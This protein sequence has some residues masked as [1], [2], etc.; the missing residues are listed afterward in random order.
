MKTTFLALAACALALTTA[1]AGPALTQTTKT[2]LTQVDPATLTTA[3]R[4]SQLIG[5]PV[6]DDAGTKIG[7]VADMLVAA[8][9]TV[10]YALITNMP[11]GREAERTVVVAASNFELIGDRL[12]IHGV[13][14][15][16]LLSLPNF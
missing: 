15:T 8:N 9:G 10:P 6:Y 13:T 14:A 2:M 12:T 3:W 1:V 4:A 16:D 11:P 5:V 7:K